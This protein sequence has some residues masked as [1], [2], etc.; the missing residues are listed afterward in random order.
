MR[1]ETNARFLE[2]AVWTLGTGKTFLT[3]RSRRPCI[4]FFALPA[5]WSGWPLQS[6]NSHLPFFALRPGRSR[7]ALRPLAVLRLLAA[8][9]GP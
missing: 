2:R 6:R 5:L 3:L 9:A 4:A 8:P 1:R 7:R